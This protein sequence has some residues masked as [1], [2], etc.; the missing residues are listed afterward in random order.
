[1]AYIGKHLESKIKKFIIILQEHV[2]T[3]SHALVCIQ[4]RQIKVHVNKYVQKQEFS[5][6]TVKSES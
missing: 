4:K 2:N 1:M 6:T 5:D 3:I